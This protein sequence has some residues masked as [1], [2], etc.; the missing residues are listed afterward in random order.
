M[1][2]SIT[3]IFNQELRAMNDDQL[4][5]KEAIKSLVAKN[6]TRISNVPDVG[7]DVIRGDFTNIIVRTYWSLNY[8]KKD[9][10]VRDN[11]GSMIP[12]LPDTMG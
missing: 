11:D 8:T 6:Y 2:S 12:C 5:F 10:H 7:Q 1:W 9:T 4:S 3:G